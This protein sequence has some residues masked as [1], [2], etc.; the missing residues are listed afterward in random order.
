MPLNGNLAL[1]TPLPTLSRCRANNN[2]CCSRWEGVEDVI[3]AVEV[4][5]RKQDVIGVELVSAIVG[6]VSNVTS[7]LLSPVL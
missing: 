6:Y 5:A 4:M 3:A 7:G 1:R 2:R